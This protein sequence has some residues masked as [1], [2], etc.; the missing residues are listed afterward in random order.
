MKLQFLQEKKMNT[1]HK[2]VWSINLTRV[3]NTVWKTS[4]LCV[5][6]VSLSC[7]VSPLLWQH[8]AVVSTGWNSSSAPASPSAC[9]PPCSD[10]RSPADGKGQG[11][12]DR[13]ENR[14][15]QPVKNWHRATFCTPYTEF[16]S[17]IFNTNISVNLANVLLASYYR[18]KICVHLIFSLVRDLVGVEQVFETTHL[19]IYSS[20]MGC[21]FLPLLLNLQSVLLHKGQF[22][23]P[24]LHYHITLYTDQETVP[25]MNYS[26][27]IN[28]TYQCYFNITEILL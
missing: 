18:I 15:L 13:L 19:S 10:S 21:M 3:N 26:M 25:I 5:C 22:P 1:K 2:A 8:T 12:D 28:T 7:P 23:F 27:K 14:D 24:Q 16:Q 6:A 9:Q 11:G 20:H 4:A 17:F